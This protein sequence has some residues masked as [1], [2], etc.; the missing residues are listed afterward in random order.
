MAISDSSPSYTFKRS[1][2]QQSVSRFESAAS[3]QSST[4]GSW[5]E[6]IGA[7]QRSVLP[8]KQRDGRAVRDE[9]MRPIIDTQ[10]VLDRFTTNMEA[11]EREILEE[12]EDNRTE[13]RE[14]VAYAGLLVVVPLVVGIVTS[15]V[16]ADPFL[17]VAMHFNHEA[18][19]LTDKDK[20]EGAE[21]VHHHELRL[22]MDS[23]IGRAP[24]LSE[25]EM[26]IELRREA[27]HL[28]DEFKE[29]KRTAVLHLLSDGTAGTTFFGLLTFVKNGRKSLFSTM[30]RIFGGL[31][32]TA[33]AFLII[34]STDILLGYH[35]EEGWT[36]AIRMLTRHYGYD[37]DNGPIFVFVAIVPVTLDAMF[38]YWIFKGLNRQSPAA[39]VTLRN[40][41]RH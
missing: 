6:Q 8:R 36:A 19:A 17:E 11:T 10:G 24:P 27:H 34:A 1:V 23:A 4:L 32:D 35:S 20:V 29:R 21:A 31:S 16:L 26:Q 2:Q 30:S 12:F 13:S 28:M 9:F 22:R 39:A 25:A 5:R 18:F 7:Q 37:V 40:M 15:A 3:A 14:A 33:K 38:K 41:D